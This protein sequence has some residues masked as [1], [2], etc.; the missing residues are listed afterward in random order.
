[1]VN[2]LIFLL[3]LLIVAALAALGLGIHLIRKSGKTDLVRLFFGRKAT[4]P[5]LVT[6]GL[7]RAFLT[8]P[9]G[10]AF[11]QV[12][13]TNGESMTGLQRIEAAITFGKLDRVPVAPFL[14]HHVARTMGLTVQEFLFDFN[15]SRLAGRA[16]Y[17][18]YGKP[19]MV[20]WFP[21][22][23]HLLFG[24]ERLLFGTDW[25]VME[26]APVQIVERQQWEV[27]DYDRLIEQGIS[28]VM[29]TRPPEGFLP[30]LRA[31]RTIRQEIRYWTKVRRAAGWVG[32]VTV[33]PFEVLSWK[34]SFEPFMVDIFKVPDKILAASDFLADGLVALAKLQGYF[35]GLRRVF[36]DCNRAS[37]TFISPAN[38]EKLVLP[39]LQRMVESFVA[40]GFDILFHLD[41]D[42]VPMLPFFRRFPPGR[43]I[44]ELEHTDIRKAKEILAG[45]MCIK[46]NISS[47]LLSLGTPDEVEREARNLIEDLAPGGGFILASGCEVPIDAPLENV[48][49]MIGAAR[50]YGRY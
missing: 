48:R 24:G 7:I 21:G 42:W 15:K 34:R 8:A 1:M 26:D 33:F 10:S 22:A 23:G 2:V 38:F 47:T 35:T 49:A 25:V 5:A 43:Y 12:P 40:D 50:K 41:T 32:A 18:L 27:A 29:L 45:H 39:S 28:K 11:Q 17:D 36:F 16:A 44:V 19:D 4:A 20:S 9:P 31:A 6:P 30:F 3:A 37:A 46:G 14:L 13:K